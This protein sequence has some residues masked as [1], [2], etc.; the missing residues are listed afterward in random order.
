MPSKNK[1]NKCK[2]KTKSTEAAE[3]ANEAAT[4]LS[5]AWRQVLNDPNSTK[6]SR[7]MA[8]SHLNDPIGMGKRFT[9]E[10]EIKYGEDQEEWAIVEDFEDGHWGNDNGTA[11]VSIASD[12]ILEKEGDDSKNIMLIRRVVREDG[13]SDP[14]ASYAKVFGACT[15]IIN[16]RTLD[17]EIRSN[18]YCVMGFLEGYGLIENMRG[19]AR[20]NIER[21]ITLNPIDWR[22][23]AMLATRHMAVQ[24]ALQALECITRA[25]ELTAEPY[26]QF[27]LGMRKGK[28]LFNLGRHDEAIASF[29][30]VIAVY[31]R[32]LKDNPKMTDK[33]VGRLAVAEFM[34]ATTYGM[35]GKSAKAANHYR[36][37][38]KKTEFDRQKNRRRN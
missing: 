2:A 30:D 37:A 26:A 31:E 25:M 16:N 7:D 15:R 18:A 33:A 12:I 38:D 11:I 3:T 6:A 29:S 8:L 35:Q 22:L 17:N 14:V 19:K 20:L 5:E 23:H 34:L 21:A 10:A 13:T 28:I 36:D 27:T 24:S 32:S 9:G 4:L 1:K